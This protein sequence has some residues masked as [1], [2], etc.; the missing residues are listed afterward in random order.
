MLIIFIIIILFIILHKNNIENLN[1]DY[2]VI[3]TNN[4][5]CNRLQVI[6]SYNQLALEQNKKLYIIWDKSEAC[7]NLFTNVFDNVPNITFSK[8]N[9]LNFSKNKIKYRGFRIHKNFYPNYDLLKPNE[10]ILN[11]YNNFIKKLTTNYIAIHIRRTDLINHSKRL[12]YILN[13]YDIFIHFINRQNNNYSIFLATDNNETQQYFKKIY[14]NR[15]FFYKNIVDNNKKRK[16]SLKNSVIDLFICKNAKVFLGTNYLG[17]GGSSFS[18]LIYDIRLENINIPRN[19]LDYYNIT[20]IMYI[21]ENNP[22]VETNK[23]PL[24]IFAD[25]YNINKIKNDNKLIYYIEC[26]IEDFYTFKIEK[27]KNNLIDNEQIFMI[28]RISEINPFKSNYFQFISNT[29]KNNIL[30]IDTINN[31][32]KNYH[33]YIMNF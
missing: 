17:F 13:D 27:L 5:L 11:K 21:D 23:Y 9:N 1:D 10:K 33:N 12:N 3:R 31:T 7:N 24:V 26:N 4:G 2:M 19:I 29:K 25:I 15:L 32:A 22:F 6:F 28:K 18:R 8:K 20:Y 14:N 30:H 16:T